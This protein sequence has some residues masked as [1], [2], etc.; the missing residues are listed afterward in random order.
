MKI[1][2]TGG[3][4]AGHVVPNLALIDQ[5]KEHYDKII[6]VGSKSGIENTL[7]AIRDDVD[8]YHVTT[9]KFVRRKIFANLLIPFK[10]LRGVHEAKQIIKSER[11]NVVFSKGG[12]VSLPVVIAAKRLKVPVVAHESD[13]VMGLA[14]RLSRRCANVICTTFEDTAF[15]EKKKG[16]WT[17]SPMRKDMF[18][19]KAEARKKLNISSPL[20][21]LVVT[22]GS[23]GSRFINRK[24]RD[25]IKS[26]SK[27]FY[28]IH[29]TGKNN[30]DKN[31]NLPNYRQI[32][33][34]NNNGVILSA[35]DV[36]VS[37]A[38]SN[39]I[40]E[41]ATL[42]KPMLLIPLP[43]GNSRGD[44]VDNAKY[45]NSRGYANFVTEEELDGQ[46]IMPYILRTYDERD[47]LSSSLKK[48]GFK[49]ANDKIVSIIVENSL[50]D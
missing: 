7:V 22:G 38:G 42:Y 1:L 43:K 5:L 50:K 10:L 3:G 46:N 21:I 45:F 6:Y 16:V 44:Q 48:A 35:A 9:T 49:P 47:R 23:L 18:I 12:F 14:N 36:V 15:K 25:E 28:V 30:I 26:L 17:G 32:E 34:A 20:P 39:T 29:I 2:L 37:R 27:K 19:E 8:F 13:L 40:F 11:P 41:L 31:I 24:I 33:F 4:T